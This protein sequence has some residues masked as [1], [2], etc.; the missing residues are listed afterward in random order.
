MNL[1]YVIC[2]HDLNGQGASQE[3]AALIWVSAKTGLNPLPT[4]IFGIFGALFKSQN[5]GNCEAL[6]CILIHPIFGMKVLQN[7]W[8]RSTI[9]PLFYLKFQGNSCTKSAPNLID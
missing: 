7:F 4:K 1:F 3:N 8:I 5:F 9:Q 6:L 2:E